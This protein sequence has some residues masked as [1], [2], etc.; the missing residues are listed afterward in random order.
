[1]CSDVHIVKN[2]RA[3]SYGEMLTEISEVACERGLCAE[4][5]KMRSSAGGSDLDIAHGLFVDRLRLRRCRLR[6]GRHVQ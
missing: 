2:T 6:N 1:M 5:L 3:V 4:A